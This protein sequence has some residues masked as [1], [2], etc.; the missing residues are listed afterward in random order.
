MGED[1][2]L[3]H[4]CKNVFKLPMTC[5]I[6]PE[7]KQVRCPECGSFHTE[8]MPHWAPIGFDVS[9]DLSMWEYECQQCQN[10]F[11][12]PVPSRPSQEKEIKC[13]ACG[14]GHIHRLTAI[15]GVP[16]YCG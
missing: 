12:L 11:K 14:G 4:Q 8:E 6:T 15:G 3:C 2:Y 16:M 13:P 9:E 1:I 7:K 10:V 5:N